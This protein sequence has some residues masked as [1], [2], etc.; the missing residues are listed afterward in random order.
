MASSLLTYAFN[1]AVLLG[2]LLYGRWGWQNI[3]HV[4]PVRRAQAKLACDFVGMIAALLIVVTLVMVNLEW[5]A[6]SG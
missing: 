2:L 5:G 4:D 3:A 1:G 6:S